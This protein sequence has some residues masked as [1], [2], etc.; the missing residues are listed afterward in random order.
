MEIMYIAN[1]G[2]LI[3]TS[4]KKILIDGLFGNFESDWCTVPSAKIVEKLETCIEPFDQ[5]DVILVT[6]AHVDH[7]NPEMVCKHLGNNPTCVLICPEQARLELEKTWGYESYKS[8]ILEITPAN[9]GGSHSVDIGG[10]GIKV[11]RLK[12]SAYYLVNEKT[13]RKYNKHKDVQNLGF[14]LEIEGKKIFHGGDWGFEGVRRKYNPLKAAKLD[15][16]FLDIG[17]YL[18]LY[19][20]ENRMMEE[21]G[22]PEETILMHI[23]P[24]FSL[25]ELTEDEQR[26]I[27]TATIFKLPM[28]IKYFR[29]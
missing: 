5:I 22:R 20:S 11:Y 23:P 12:H 21:S 16:A 8:R 4:N 26:A 19:K 15:V 1:A 6:H 28:E 13:G 10:I 7:F 14:M 17:T 29:Q 3:K 2:F 18:E 25:E 27:S 24:I 9:E